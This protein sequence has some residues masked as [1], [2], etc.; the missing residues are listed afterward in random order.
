MT[1]SNGLKFVVSDYGNGQ[2]KGVFEYGVFGN[3]QQKIGNF[4]QQ[5]LSRSGLSILILKLNRGVYNG[6]NASLKSFM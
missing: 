1:Y 2:G 3:P 5:T 6:N 4:T